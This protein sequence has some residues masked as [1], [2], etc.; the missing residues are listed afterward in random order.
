MI[1]HDHYEELCALAVTRQIAPDDL[2]ALNEHVETCVP[3]RN[4]LRDFRFIANNVVPE[5]A[6]KR[7]FCAPPVG[8]TE[9]FIARAHSEG[10]ALKR[11]A[12]GRAAVAKHARNFGL[13]AVASLL[14][15]FG[16]RAL[17]P[18]W[19]RQSEI[20]T[21]SPANPLDR[22][23]QTDAVRTEL[24]R[25]NTNLKTRIDEL[26]RQLDQARAEAERERRALDSSQSEKSAATVR[27]ADLESTEANLR[28]D[29]V[30]RDAQIAELNSALAHKK[31][32]VDQLLSVKARH[33][34]W[35][36]TYQV[37]LN[38][39]Q[40]QVDS[41]KEAA[42]ESQQLSA[43]AEQAKD[44]IV[45]RHLHIVDVDDTDGTERQRPF[46]RIFYAEGQSLV[47]YAYDLNEPRKLT[48][49]LN[50]YVWGGREGV[51][52]PVHSLGIF[53]TDDE[54]EARWVLRFDDA[55]VLAQI[56]YI[57][58]TVESTKKP[59][60]QPSGRQI[61]FAFLGPKANHP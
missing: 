24:V 22:A 32:D 13:L 47:F 11:K 38:H 37:E 36:Q 56:N 53:H 42:S 59:I 14:V 29:L 16:A 21:R 39:L 49:K 46:G 23:G 52:K 50:F 4:T 15:Y 48:T 61:L 5:L 7:L 8:M 17:R 51:D 54:K 26:L 2:Q 28:H 41:L 3:C 27:L 58:V 9:R 40:A 1:E 30:D 18:E 57:F 10:I 43:A 25:D 45:A 20:I 33:E 44:L 31:Q 12:K 19:P 35:D 6:T 55:S 60:T 34:L